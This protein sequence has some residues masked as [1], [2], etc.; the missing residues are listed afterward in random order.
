MKSSDDGLTSCLALPLWEM[1]RETKPFLWR[2]KAPV[3]KWHACIP[4]SDLSQSFQSFIWELL[5]N[6]KN[7]ACP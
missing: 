3:C 7:P 1:G 2:D 6:L 4:T 5:T